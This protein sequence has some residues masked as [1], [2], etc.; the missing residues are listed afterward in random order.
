MT[1]G[2]GGSRRP[3]LCFAIW[4]F[5]VGGAERM[6]IGLLKAIPRDRY[7]V[8]VV[9][10]RA[11]GV[12]AG[13]LEA[14]GIPVH[15]LGKTR[16]LS[17]AAFARLVAFLRRVRPDLL[18]T[19]LWTADLW[20]RLAAPLC[21]VRR[22]VVTEQ[23]VDVWKSRSRRL[24]DRALF[25][26]T[27]AVI[28]VGDEVQ[29]FYVEEIGVPAA[30]TVVIPNAIDPS[31]FAGLPGAGAFRT[32]SGLD[33]ATFLF[34]CA[35]RLHPQ[36][37]HPV[38]FEAVRLLRDRG[39]PAFR[40]VLVGDG[41]ERSALEQLAGR[42]AVTDRLLF[43]GARTDVPRIL[44]DADAFVLSSDYEGTSLAILEAMAAGLP[45]VATDVGANRSVVGEAA[46][47][48]VPP[49]EPKALADAMGRLLCDRALGRELGERG[50]EIV[51]ARYSIESAA[52]A[53]LGLFDQ[54]LRGAGDAGRT[55]R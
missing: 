13:E 44:A 24:V 12:Y 50:R 43:L 19:H 52:R 31:R 39:A 47:I 38:L 36:K 54:L 22:V 40:V 2:D 30:K 18:N 32:E 21:G 7:D 16:K 26:L 51:H 9:T 11:K 5:G 33:G 20:G 6:L 4:S 1:S 49:R 3:R 37:A 46:G 17:P 42:L 28:C 23:N 14:A 27:D 10:L 34:A 29:R 55:G 41:P 25:T 8:S 45:I 15:C 48:I 35:A 53:T